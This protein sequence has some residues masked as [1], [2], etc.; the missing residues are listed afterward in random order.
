MDDE[1]LAKFLLKESSE[2]EDK[3]VRYWLDAA[4]A[5]QKYFAQLKTIW[6]LSDTL[7]NGKKRDENQAWESFKKRR[8]NQ[9][10]EKIKTWKLQTIWLKVAAVFV[11][12]VGC[13]L[14]YDA[15]GPDNY[16]VLTALNQ[17]RNDHLPDGSVLTLNK[18]SKISYASDFKEN[19]VINMEKGDVFFEVAKDKTHP[20]IIHIDQLMVEVVGTSFNIRHAKNSTELNVETGIVK[21]RLGNEEL[22]LYHGER[23]LVT[24]NMKK[25]IK[26]QSIDQLYNY[27][28][29]HVFQA[30]NIAL[31]KLVNALNEAYN[32]NIILD[33]HV[34]HLSISTT[35]KLGSVNENLRVICET[36]DLKLSR[37]GNEILLTYKD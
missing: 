26:E 9:N 3:Q 13:W 7:K 31:L 10:T 8:E 28:R 4:E 30:N 12:A 36:L 35:L 23:M 37:K 34:K 6:Q 20:F 1:L 29:S 32:T 25:L 14:M 11:V 19:R 15:Y 5:N 18:H 22:N 21:V 16:V 33:E 27:Y 17:V 24:S 2:E